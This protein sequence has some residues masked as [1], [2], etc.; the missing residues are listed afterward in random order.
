MPPVL[1]GWSRL[2]PPG[3]DAPGTRRNNREDGRDGTPAKETHRK[4]G[5]E[6][7]RGERTKKGGY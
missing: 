7:A 4:A 2:F 3:K 1:R 6:T 5:T